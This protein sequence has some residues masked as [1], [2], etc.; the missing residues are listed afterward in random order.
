MTKPSLNKKRK[1]MGVWI[2]KDIY[3]DLKQLAYKNG[4]TLSQF[5]RNILE[6]SI[7]AR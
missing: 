1:Y 2:D 7:Y 6:E 4:D 5:I 3:D